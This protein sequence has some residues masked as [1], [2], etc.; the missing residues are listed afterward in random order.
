M[1]AISTYK[2]HAV[3][4]QTR[5]RLIV[6][7]YEGAIKFLRQA[8]ASLEAGDYVE[9]GK[10]LN[11]AQA[12]LVELDTC[13][14]M[15]AG[16]EIAQN[17]HGLYGFMSQRLDEANM[18]RDPERIRQVITCLEELLEGWKAVTA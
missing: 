9:K 4:T 6:L 7:L 14:D 15:E 1:D 10:F 18:K 17:L 12:I 13:L 11:K 3:S 5:G 2:E 8:I 16:G